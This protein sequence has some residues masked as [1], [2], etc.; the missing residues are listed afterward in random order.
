MVELM[1]EDQEV[2]KD[3]RKMCIGQEENRVIREDKMTEEL[4]R[5]KK[6]EKE[7]SHQIVQL[8]VLL[9]HHSCQ[10]DLILNFK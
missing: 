5:L 7:T 1:K 8:L 6:G 3:Q 4:K 10:S 2:G 9:L